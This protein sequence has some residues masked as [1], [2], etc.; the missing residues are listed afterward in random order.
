[1]NSKVKYTP[2]AQKGA[3]FFCPFFLFLNQTGRNGICNEVI[4]RG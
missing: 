4:F 2:D 3:F 1:M